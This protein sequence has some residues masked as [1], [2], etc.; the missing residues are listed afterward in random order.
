M[1]SLAASENQ[2]TCCAQRPCHHGL[3][4]HKPPSYFTCLVVH[5]GDVTVGGPIGRINR[6][7][8]SAGK[9]LALEMNANPFLHE[10]AAFNYWNKC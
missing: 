5:C 10:L 4:I 8:K 3:R 7:R 6:D 9:E 1:T 2:T